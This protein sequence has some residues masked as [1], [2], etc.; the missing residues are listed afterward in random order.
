MRRLKLCLRFLRE[1]ADTYGGCYS[2]NLLT[3]AKLWIPWQ[4][5]TLL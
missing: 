4:T 1:V 5:K 2:V 3:I